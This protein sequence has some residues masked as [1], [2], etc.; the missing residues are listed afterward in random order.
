MQN[1]LEYNL[2]QTENEKTQLEF[3]INTLE[4][5]ME[6]LQEKYDST[7]KTLRLQAANEKDSRDGWKER[8]EKEHNELAVTQKTLDKA[9][10]EISEL[11][12]KIQTF[13]R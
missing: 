10:S 11:K 4:T 6:A 1:R 9:R 13:T 8:Y 12:I 3:Q 7:H 5:Q 2:A